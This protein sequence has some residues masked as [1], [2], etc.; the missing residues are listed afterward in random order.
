MDFVKVGTVDS[1]TEFHSV[2]ENLDKE[3]MY[4]AVELLG[5]LANIESKGFAGEAMRWVS[6]DKEPA[7]KVYFG[8]TERGSVEGAIWAAIEIGTDNKSI[9]LLKITDRYAGGELEYENLLGDA[10]YRRE[11]SNW[12]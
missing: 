11:R 7:I 4:Q 12:P 8:R 3:R 10:L 2:W 6:V 1:H 5:S 9:R